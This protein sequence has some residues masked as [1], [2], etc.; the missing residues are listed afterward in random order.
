MKRTSFFRSVCALAIP[1]ALQS[2]LQSSFSVVDQVMLGKLGEVTIAGVGFAGKFSSIFSV[3]ASAV[4]AVAGIMISQYL[5]QRNRAEVRRSFYGNLY[6]SVA[7]GLV[8]TL[9]C[10]LLPEP[11]MGLYT[12]DGATRAEAAGYLRILSATFLPMA[13]ATMLSTLLRCMEKARLPLYATIVSALLNTALNAVL[14]FGLLGFAP[15][16]AKGAAIATAISQLVNF[17]LMLLLL[18]RC[19]HVLRGTQRAQGHFNWKQYGAMLLP[20]LICE[21]FWS[22]GENVYAAIYGH[23]STEASAAMNLVNPVQG[24]M[25]GALC[26]LPQ[27]A[28]VIIGRLLGEKK[29]DEAY[30]ASKKLLLYGLCGALLLSCAV[31][32]ASPLYVRIYEVEGSVRRMARQIMLAYAIVAPFKVL[33]MILGGGI[34][35]S[36]GRTGYVMAIDL[37]GTWV[38]GV[39]IGLLTAFALQLPV[40]WVYFFLSL[41]EAVRFAISLVVFHR[42]KWMQS[43]SA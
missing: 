35:R 21:V 14:I 13:G 33:N 29:F 42:K 12:R 5:G 8:F 37:L 20:L 31:V 32:V 10:L 9:L 26:G 36:G 28:G 15:M 39:P 3:V 2:L 43:L 23:M 1:V 40:A 25:I 22:L 4:G 18:L 11:I 27:A 16:G 30:H 17:L 19:D 38:F 41:E 7:L 6:I 24:I 34:L